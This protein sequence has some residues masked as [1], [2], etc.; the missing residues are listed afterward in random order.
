MVE[1][2]DERLKKGHEACVNEIPETIERYF[3]RV[4]GVDNEE[5]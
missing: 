2:G 3:R 4:L 5:V 1:S